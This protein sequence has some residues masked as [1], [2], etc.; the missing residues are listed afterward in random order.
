MFFLIIDNWKNKLIIMFFIKIKKRGLNPLL[1]D[2][3]QKD[4]LI[5]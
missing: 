2:Q 1:I 3:F 5:F 4:N